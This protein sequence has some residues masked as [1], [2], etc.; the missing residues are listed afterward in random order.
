VDLGEAIWAADELPHTP[1]DDD[2][3]YIDW[4]EHNDH[5][6]GETPLDDGFEDEWDGQDAWEGGLT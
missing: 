4:N 6:D 3:L 5:A 2:Q 1:L